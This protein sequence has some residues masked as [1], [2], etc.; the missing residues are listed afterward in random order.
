M[1]RRNFLTSSAAAGLVAGSAAAA[2]SPS[3]QYVELRSYQV[4]FS[5]SNQNERLTEFLEKHHLPMTK[6][7][8]IAPVGYFQVYLGPDMPKYFT[9][10]CYDSLADME[11]K[12]AARGGD[13]KWSKAADAFG[14]APDPP[15]V[16]V[17]S[18]LL[19]A[20]DGMPK[21]EVPPSEADKPARLFDL[22]TYESETFR[23]TREKVNMFNTEEIKI[24]RRAGVNP[25]FFGE[26]VVGSKMPN[27]TYMVWY[28]NM[29][30]RSAAWSKFLQDPD[31]K[32]IS[33]KPGWSNAEIVSNISNTFLQPLPFSPIR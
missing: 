19:K 3:N 11:K 32:R 25:V 12:W 23:D 31:W 8:G 21:L 2:G 30:A 26:T 24:F 28:D 13:E 29:D 27:L 4:R 22:R 7:V 16:R 18:W 6:R 10:A 15:F 17:E 20:F 1:D 14:A 9:L 33:V 5:K